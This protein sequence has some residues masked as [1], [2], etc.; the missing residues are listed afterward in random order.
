MESSTNQAKKYSYNHLLVGLVA[1]FFSPLLTFLYL[2]F[3]PITIPTTF[4]LYH[5]YK[6]QIKQHISELYQNANTIVQNGLKE[7]VVPAYN[8][9]KTKIYEIVDLLLSQIKNIKESILK[10]YNAAKT[11]IYEIADFLF[12]QI[13]NRKESILKGYNAAKTKIYEI[14][15]FL[16]SPIKNR[17]ESILKFFE[18]V[19]TYL[20]D[21]QCIKKLVEY[22]QAGT[23]IICDSKNILLLILNEAQVKVLNNKYVKIGTSTFTTYILPQLQYLYPIFRYIISKTGTVISQVRENINKQYLQIPKKK[24][25][26]IGYA[27]LNES[28]KTIQNLNPE[29]EIDRYRIQLHQYAI[30]QFWKIKN[31]KDTQILELECGDAVGLSY[32]SSAYEP[33]RCLGVDSSESQIQENLKLYSEL[34]RLKFETRSPLEI[35]A[36]CAPNTFDV[37]LGLELKKKEAFRNIDFKS[38]IKIVSTL[39]KDDGYLII[40]DYD[41]QEEIQKFQEEIQVNGLVITEKND[42]TVGI[43]QAM[44][45][46]IRNIKQTFRQNGGYIAKFLS[47]GLKPDQNLL[48]QFKDRQQIYMVYILKKATL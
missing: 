16:F 7:Y 41:T 30:T 19:Q 15:D 45:L 37:I 23:A 3:F 40:G 13:K 46:Q 22:L 25:E 2:L 10:G 32:F 4:I 24:I 14:V 43:T 1:L 35:G 48:Q 5:F 6:V 20:L 34:E 44:K 36:L 28:G 29:Q 26:I 8:A 33:Q 42:F 27:I 12:S 21:Y 38:Y 18:D 11:K 9:A 47:E 31:F 39:L 17:K